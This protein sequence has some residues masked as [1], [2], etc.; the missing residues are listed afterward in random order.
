M[1]FLY[2]EQYTE[3]PLNELVRKLWV[4]DNASSMQSFDRKTVLPNGCFNLSLVTGAGLEVRNRRG[5][6]VMPEG[7]YFCG[8]ARLSVDTLIR[9]FT[10][11]T[12]VQIHPWS[13][14]RFTNASFA[15]T[16]DTIVPLYSLLP[17]LHDAL[18]GYIG[19]SEGEVLSFLHTRLSEFVVNVELP[20]LRNACQRWQQTKGTVGVAELAQE[21]SCSTRQLEKYFRHHVGLTPKEFTTTLQVRGV[22]DALQDAANPTSLAQL[23]LTYG[24]YD[25][26]HFIKV[27]RRMVQVSPG[28]FDPIAYMLPL[29]GAGY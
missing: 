3:A 13:M 19:R 24:F 21:L 14:A 26:P 4:M 18:Q 12:M 6:L 9:P 16:T 28:K 8:Q 5:P 27:F 17:A 1:S 7:V 29:S 15:H 23:A 22:V 20:L 11:V 2:R 25:Q 10:S